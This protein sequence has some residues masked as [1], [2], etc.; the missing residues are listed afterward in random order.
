MN[1]FIV[2][3][4][5]EEIGKNLEILDELRQY[6]IQRFVQD[7][8]IHKLAERCLQLCIECVL[9]IA[10]YLIS[11]KSWPRPADNTDAIIELGDQGVL[12]RAFA[13]TIAG[14]VNFR[15][16]LVHAYLKID[17]AIVFDQLNRLDDFREFERFVLAYLQKTP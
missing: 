16:I 3:E 2:H 17:R 14:M 5:L 4:R 11:Q 1:H 15:N 13:E 9:D 8:K 12:P 6:P 10:H 7:P